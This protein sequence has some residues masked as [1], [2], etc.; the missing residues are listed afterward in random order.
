MLAGKVLPGF[1]GISGLPL[2]I[3]PCGIVGFHDQAQHK[4]I[5]HNP[6][7]LILSHSAEP[8]LLEEGKTM[9]GHVPRRHQLQ[10]AGCLV[11]ARS[12]GMPACCLHACM[13][14][15]VRVWCGRMALSSVMRHGPLNLPRAL[16]RAAGV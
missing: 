13:L 15:H 5:Y 8:C 16:C 12:T 2:C 10:P 1:L 4:T 3:F 6:G 9:C 14:V 7:E 11:Q